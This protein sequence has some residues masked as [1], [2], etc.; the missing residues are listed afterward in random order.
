MAWF[1]GGGG[2][3]GNMMG[4]LG[5]RLL[6]NP[7]GNPYTGNSTGGAYG[8]GSG[9]GSG[10]MFGGY[11]EGGNQ[12]PDES[13]IANARARAAGGGYPPRP[14]QQPPGGPMLRPQP[15]GNGQ[16]PGAGVMPMRPQPFGNGQDPR[17]GMTPMGGGVQLRGGGWAY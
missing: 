17:A 9:Y 10:S 7:G 5:D 15:F 11:R 4:G 13:W 16:P 6:G 2:G 3:F 12:P 14:G 1:G 8:R